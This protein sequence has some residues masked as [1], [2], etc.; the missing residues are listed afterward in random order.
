VAAESVIIWA[1][2]ASK[3]QGL[4]PGVESPPIRVYRFQKR[5]FAKVSAGGQ[6]HRGR[7]LDVIWYRDVHVPTNVSQITNVYPPLSKTGASSERSNSPQIISEIEDKV[8]KRIEYL[9][10]QAAKAER[11]ARSV[12]DAVT[13]QRLMNYAAECRAEVASGPDSRQAA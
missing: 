10:E 11:L 3:C 7:P 5:L 4:K 6:V 1:L 13:V 2:L 9:K 12:V 8:V